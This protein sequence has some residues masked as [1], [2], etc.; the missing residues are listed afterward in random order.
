MSH[1]IEYGE[2]GTSRGVILVI[3]REP[4]ELKSRC[5]ESHRERFN[6]R[7]RDLIEAGRARYKKVVL[8]DS[9]AGGV[10][11]LSRGR[12]AIIKDFN[13][14]PYVGKKGRPVFSSYWV[15]EYLPITQRCEHCSTKLEIKDGVLKCPACNLSYGE[16]DP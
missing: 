2:I 14:K 8:L 11:G 10:A 12:R 16:I 7:I 5:F 1:E 13:F 15:M 9:T 6:E 3:E 4:L